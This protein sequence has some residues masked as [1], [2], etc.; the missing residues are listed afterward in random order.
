MEQ[1]SDEAELKKLIDTTVIAGET[2]IVYFQQENP[3]D[4]GDLQKDINTIANVMHL[5]GTEFNDK[6]IENAA[7]DR[8]LRINNDV[9]LLQRQVL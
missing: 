5:K 9:T 6:F 3:V 4:V 7:R 2:A 8:F 1:K